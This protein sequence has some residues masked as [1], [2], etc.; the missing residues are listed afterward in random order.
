MEYSIVNDYGLFEI[1]NNGTI[2][3]DKI[4]VATL[5]ANQEREYSLTV[6]VVDNGGNGV[7]V[8]ICGPTTNGIGDC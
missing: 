7:Q 6:N 1:Y 2:I 4:K 5:L 3:F 8:L